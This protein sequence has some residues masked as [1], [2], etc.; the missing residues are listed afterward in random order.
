MFDID[1]LKRDSE[2]MLAISVK[3][4]TL[5]RNDALTELV[6]LKNNFYR[7]FGKD[8]KARFGL[9]GIE[10]PQKD[11]LRKS[12]DLLFDLDDVLFV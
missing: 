12:G 5:D 2:E 7:I 1:G 8:K 3:A 10:I 4:R 11:E 9:F 6:S